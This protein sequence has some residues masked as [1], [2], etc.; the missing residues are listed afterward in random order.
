MSVTINLQ[1][2]VKMT[3]QKTDKNCIRGAKNAHSSAVIPDIT[4][5]SAILPDFIN[6]QG[7]AGRNIS[8]PMSASIVG[9]KMAVCPDSAFYNC[10]GMTNIFQPRR[11]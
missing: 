4:G 3:R 2:D 8:C 6:D 9:T 11:I 1:F 10:M 5:T 7:S